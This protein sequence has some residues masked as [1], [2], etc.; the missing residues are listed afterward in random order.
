MRGREG[1]REGKE[2]KRVG[3]EY[4]WSIKQESK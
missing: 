1:G 4:A 2:G 3:R